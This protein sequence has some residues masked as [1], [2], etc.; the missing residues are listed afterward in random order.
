MLLIIYCKSIILPS[1]MQQ[2]ANFEINFY[3]ILSEDGNLLDSNLKQASLINNSQELLNMYKCMKKTRLFDAKVINLQKTG[4]TGTYPSSLWHEAIGVAI[5]SSM[6]KQDIFCPYYRDLGTMLYRGVMLE[7]ILAYWGGDPGGSNFK[8]SPKDFPIC[9]PIASQT[10]H[11][12]GA[13]FAL[14]HQGLKNVVVTTIGDG[15]TSR[16]DFYEALNLA[17]AWQLPLVFIIINNRFAISTSRNLQTGA[18]TLAQKAIAAGIE[19]EQV[20]G[21]DILAL[22]SRLD[23]AINNAR[24]NQ[25]PKV[26]EALTYRMG[27]H[28]TSDDA[29]RYRETSEKQQYLNTDPLIRF[30]NFLTNKFQF[31]AKDD[32]DLEAECN[33]EIQKAVD[34]YLNLPETDPASTMFD[35]LYAQLPNA[36]K[37]QKDL[38]L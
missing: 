1:I 36:L 37:I 29:S 21:N 8:Y 34:N 18:T 33:L 31:S 13:A 15:G 28:T 9:V 24:I 2:I 26:I 25:E 23:L 16:G 27:D 4:K 22:R 6:S 12:A 3:Q 20:D 35:Y 19:G 17:K 38:L 5:G 32:L 14:K 10:L 11:A 7:E 30:K